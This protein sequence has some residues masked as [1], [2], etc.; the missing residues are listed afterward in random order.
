M[1]DTQLLALALACMWVGGYA[2]GRGRI[3]RR[4]VRWADWQV[5]CASRHSPWF[6]TAV[7]ILLVSAGCLWV[8]RPHRTLANY[9]AWKAR[10]E[11]VPV[12][13]RDPNWAA[14]RAHDTN[15]DT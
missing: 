12:P 3:V 9:R 6:W 10:E 2:T 1:T 15:G 8:F 11:P 14:R 5:A 4:L 13:R 7:P